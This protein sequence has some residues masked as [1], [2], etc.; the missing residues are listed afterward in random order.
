MRLLEDQAWT[1]TVLKSVEPA[2]QVSY[3]TFAFVGVLHQQNFLT[4]VGVRLQR[5]ILNSIILV[6]VPSCDRTDLL[7]IVTITF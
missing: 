3:S 6:F 5:V 1:C 4:K 2:K 7:P